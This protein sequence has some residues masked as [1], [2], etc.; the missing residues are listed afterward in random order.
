[1][2]P[3]DAD[4]LDKKIYNDVPISVF[5]SVK[6][7]AAVRQL[8]EDA[9]TIDVRPVVHGHWIENTHT[10]GTTTGGYTIWHDYTCSVCGGIMGRKD[11]AYCYKCGAIMDEKEQN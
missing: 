7:M 4:A 1:M 11:D 9:P 2:R 10:C 8:I 3:I 5:G 6:K